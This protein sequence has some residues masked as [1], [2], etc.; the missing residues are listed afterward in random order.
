MSSVI[1][2]P[3]RVSYFYLF[4]FPEVE[5]TYNVVPI[6]VVQQSDS[7]IYTYIYIHTH[8]LQ[9]FLSIMT[10]PTKLDSSLY[11]GGEPCLF[12]V[13]VM[14][15]IY[16]PRTPSPSPSLPHPLGSLRS[17]QRRE[18]LIKIFVVFAIIVNAAMGLSF[19]IYCAQ[20]LFCPHLPCF[21]L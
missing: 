8:I 18:F 17:D 1:W 9:L 6:S 12:I 2:N 21:D 4:F 13:N 15:C 20:K 5:L 7:C 16:Q 19:H 10:Y 3:K 11:Y 14:V